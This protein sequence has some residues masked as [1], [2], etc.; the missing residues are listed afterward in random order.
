[1]TTIDDIVGKLEL[2]Q[3]HE[4]AAANWSEISF[5]MQPPIGEATL[6]QLEMSQ[7]IELP[8]GYREFLLRIGNGGAGPG[9][10][11]HSLEQALEER[12]EGIYSLAD[13]FEPPASSRD[14]FDLRAPGMLPIYHDGCA[15]YG[16]LV[17]SGPARGQVWSFVEV[18]PGW[19]PMCGEDIV[20]ED[21]EPFEMDGNDM[22]AYARWYDAMLLPVNEPLRMTFLERY[23]Q[24]LDSIITSGE[25]N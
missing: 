10:G 19:V 5:Q 14:W 23:E 13:P 24:W 22:D 6:V 11:L 18:A 3:Q 4:G 21:G 9:Y 2:A 1:M 8:E 7:G 17:V 15:F 20:G 12:R 16:G 25:S